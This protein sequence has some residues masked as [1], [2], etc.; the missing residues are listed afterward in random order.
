MSNQKQNKDSAKN[1]EKIKR[2]GKYHKTMKKSDNNQNS[3]VKSKKQ[4][5]YH[6]RKKTTKQTEKN[7]QKVFSSPV[8]I[9]F[10]GG[11]NEVGKNLT[12]IEYNDEI[13]IIDCGL[14]FPDASMPGIDLVIPDFTYLEKNADKIKAIFITHG[15][16]DHIGGLAYLNVNFQKQKS[17]ER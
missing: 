2:Y 13:I 9:A 15:H 16:E 7:T 17:A 10:L 1:T 3:T 8:K 11:L 5:A 14:A 12:V 4:S 6:Y